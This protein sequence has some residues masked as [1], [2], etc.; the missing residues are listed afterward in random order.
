MKGC[1][2]KRCPF[3]FCFLG[4]RV[5]DAMNCHEIDMESA[6]VLESPDVVNLDSDSSWGIRGD[7]GDDAPACETESEESDL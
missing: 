3:F 5:R 6:A 1:L 4:Y 7:S 2:T